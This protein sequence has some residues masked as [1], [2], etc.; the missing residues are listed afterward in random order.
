MTEEAWS[1]ISI[2]VLDPSGWPREWIRAGLTELE[3]VS[4]ELAAATAA[5]VA[6]LGVDGRDTPA[7]IV[8]CTGVSGGEARRRISMARTISKLPSLGPALAAAMVSTEHVRLLTPIAGRD[9]A[10]DLVAAALGQGPEALKAAIERLLI[11]DDFGEGLARLQHQRRSVRFF[12]ADH[13]MVG[14]RAILPPI[15]GAMV[16]AM[17]SEA[18]DRSWR[19]AHPERPP[20]HDPDAY[21]PLER[22][23][24]DAFISCLDKLRPGASSGSPRPSPVPAVVLTIGVDTGAAEVVGQGSVPLSTALDFAAEHT[25]ELYGAILGIDGTVLAAGKDRRF[26]TLLQ[27]I[28][29]VVRDKRCVVRG[30]DVSHARCELHHFVEFGEGGWTVVSNLGAVC[31]AH[32]HFLHRNS[33]RLVRGPDGCEVVDR[34]GNVVIGH[35][36]PPPPP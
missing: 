20:A 31:P 26:A 4:R 19:A 29:V 16:R 11:G 9:G 12:N 28:A 34:H 21:E 33:F 6:A 27:R 32:H 14:M 10:D 36:P 2:P 7:E 25:A 1:H 22:R 8:R 23:M 13:G 24:A 30:C 18:T 15:D 35:G 3:R 5:L 17:I